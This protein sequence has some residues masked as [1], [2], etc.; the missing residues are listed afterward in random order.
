MSHYK[1]GCLVSTHPV[2]PE[3][4][5]RDEKCEQRDTQQ[6]CPDVTQIRVVLQKQKDVRSVEHQIAVF[7]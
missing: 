3:E 2:D 6:G 7:Q 5:V 1:T 4:G